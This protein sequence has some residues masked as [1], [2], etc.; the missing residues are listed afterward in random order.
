MKILG[1]LDHP[2]ILKMYEFFEDEIFYYIDTEICKGGDITE[3]IYTRKEM[4]SEKEAAILMKQILQCVNFCHKNHLIHRDLK[5][6]NIILEENKD[7]TQIKII[8]FG[9]AKH[10]EK[11][12]I[13]HDPDFD[14]RYKCPE[15]YN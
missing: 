15:A 5:T 14:A 2:N 12:K 6:D 11:N 4:Y 13:Y 10:F 7:S 9:L 3:E 1:S 8:D